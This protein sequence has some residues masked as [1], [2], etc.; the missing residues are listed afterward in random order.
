MQITSLNFESTS[1]LSVSWNISYRQKGDVGV[2]LV[3]HRLV[4]AG[5]HEPDVAVNG[6]DRGHRCHD[7]EL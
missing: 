6:H 5:R 4:G 1:A 3:A 2:A 7:P